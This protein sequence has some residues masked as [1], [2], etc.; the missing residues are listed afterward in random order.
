MDHSFYISDLIAKK[1]KGTIS[2][3]EMEKLESWMNESSENLEIYT[4]ATDNKYLVNKLEVYQLFKKN[5]VKAALENELFSAKTRKLYPNVL[6]RYAAVLIPFIIMVGVSWYF[7]NESKS[8]PLSSLD[9]VVKPGSQKAILKLSD[10]KTLELDDSSLLAEL[11]EGD[12]KVINERNSLIYSSEEESV[13]SKAVIYNELITPRGGGYKLQL[14]D[15]TVVTMNAGSSLR[16][17]VAFSDSIRQVFLEGE[18]Y[19]DVSHNGKPFIVSCESMDV[20]VLGTSF[21]VSSYADDAEI[22]TTLVEGKV[23][24]T[25]AGNPD[26]ASEGIILAPDDQAI[27]SRA[28]ATVEV[29]KVN[30]SQYTSWVMGKFEFSNANLNEVMKRLARWYDF[31]YEFE[32]DAAK[33]YHFTARIDNDQSISSILEM[34][35]MTTDVK[36][37]IRDQIIVIL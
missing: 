30:T 24:V 26:L 33:D 7:L 18:A 3:E 15:G 29:V 31:E 1:N 6:L 22:K 5:K 32:S 36:F 19:F 16:Y 13:V 9:T 23:K 20:R 11:Q 28:D 2:L 4:R 10:G 17:P 12:A 37:E 25:T 21:N 35:E 27:F 14:A 34:L 8:P